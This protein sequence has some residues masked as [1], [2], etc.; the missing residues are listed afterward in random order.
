MTELLR[1][2]DLKEALQG[3]WHTE[4]KTSVFSGIGT[5]TR[6]SLNGQVFFALKG[7]R[8]DG[9]DFLSEAQKKGAALLITSHREKTQSFIKSHQNTTG[10]L[11]VEDTLTA[12]QKLAVFWRKKLNLKI[13]CFTGSSGKTTTKQFTQTLLSSKKALS[14][15]HSFNNHWGVPLSLL[16]AR[17]P[18]AFFIQEIGASRKGEIATLTSLCDPFVAAVT[19]IGPAHLEGFG[20][21]ESLALEKQQI[22]EKSP[23]AHWIFNE[24]NPFT[25]KMLKNLP[26]KREKKTSPAIF[27]FSGKNKKAHVSLSILQET[28]NEMDIEGMIGR[29]PGQTKV[30][31][32]GDCQLENLM[33]ACAAALACQVN[34]KDIWQRLSECQ[35]P[36]GRQSWFEWKERQVFILFDA[37][38]ANPLSM[39]FFLKQC[40]K[41]QT[42]KNR[43]IFILGDMKE[44]GEKS[45]EHHKKLC[46]N[47]S[48]Q[49]A[50]F[51]W[52]IGEHRNAVEATL[53]NTP[54]Q[55][56]FIKSENYEKSLLLKLK[57]S[58]QP[59]DIL[60]IKASRSLKLEQA[61]L[62]LTGQKV[63]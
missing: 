34:P 48:I 30:S 55:G 45:E 11:Q 40:H 47:P 56:D 4:G 9:H 61:L 7:P 19:S 54:F 25:K 32:S 2:E 29:V 49:S 5:D 31:F 36:P 60:G 53:K 63:F 37:Y 57:A 59:H 44:L 26:S 23:Q 27:I 39:E 8:F 17:E 3:Q 35:L 15:P 51:I 33:C 62:D 12:L 38:N 46:Q 52:Y 1:K 41:S 43:L 28:K 13:I 14:S 10:L 50:D 21:M 20:N 22:Y 6:K 24:D 18:E 42:R 58:L 16:S